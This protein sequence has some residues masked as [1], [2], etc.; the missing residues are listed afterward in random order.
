MRKEEKLLFALLVTVVCVLLVPD[1]SALICML[2]LGNFLRESGVTDRLVNAAQN[3]IINVVTIL[4]G[5][6]VGVTMAG[7]NFLNGKTLMILG[8][9]IVAF[10]VATASGLL[11]AKLIN[12]VSK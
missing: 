5:T 6:S 11:M 12:L 1:A 8:M 2:M 7:D 4:L 3:E 9:G 10:S